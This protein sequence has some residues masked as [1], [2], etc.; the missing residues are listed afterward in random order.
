MTEEICIMNR[1]LFNSK[2]LDFINFA[3]LFVLPLVVMT[4]SNDL[5]PE[6]R[7]RERKQKKNGLREKIEFVS[8]SFEYGNDGQHHHVGYIIAGIIVPRMNTRLDY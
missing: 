6:R 1:R 3:A 5:D 8:F 7:E 4:V 2:L